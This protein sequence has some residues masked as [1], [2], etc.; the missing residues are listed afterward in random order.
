MTTRPLV[1]E[2]IEPGR[3]RATVELA[4]G[5]LARGAVR[6]GAVALPFG[7]L[8]VSGSAEWS[9]DRARLVELQQLSTRSG[10]Q[11]RL[12]LAQIWDA[13]RPITWRSIRAWTLVLWA[14]LFIADAALTRLGISLLPQKKRAPVAA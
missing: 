8:A 14:V 7:P 13:P 10:G 3:F 1:W 5:K 9:F 4:P 12:D 2:K 11:E 6:V